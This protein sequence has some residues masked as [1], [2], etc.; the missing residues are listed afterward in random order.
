MA[1]TDI[2]IQNT[3]IFI[4]A[5]SNALLRLEDIS[6]F[7]RK[8][9]YGP[10][11]EL[12]TKSLVFIFPQK[13]KK[14]IRGQTRHGHKRVFQTHTSNNQGCEDSCVCVWGEAALKMKH[15]PSLK[16]REKT[17]TDDSVICNGIAINGILRIT[18]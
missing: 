9:C 2:H 13:Q 4:E 11:N 10:D 18:H 3:Q 6:S 17:R 7:L 16:Q 1:L 12:R 15:S 8:G 5:R 14:D